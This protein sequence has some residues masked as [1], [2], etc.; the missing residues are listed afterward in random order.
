MRSKRSSEPRTMRRSHASR[1][2][3]GTSGDFNLIQQRTSHCPGD[4]L[5]GMRPRKH[6]S[7][8]RECQLKT[9]LPSARVLCYINMGGHDFRMVAASHAISLRPTLL[10]HISV[11]T[12]DCNGSC[13][14]PV[15]CYIVEFECCTM[16]TYIASRTCLA[17]LGHLLMSDSRQ[18]G[19]I[20]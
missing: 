9:Q 18:S 10:L 2:P 11:C 20:H 3:I 5:L 19:Q 13:N 8:S 4:M 12:D 14:K 15:T 6:T 7:K 16:M 17:G 1:T